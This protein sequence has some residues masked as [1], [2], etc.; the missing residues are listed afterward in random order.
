MGADMRRR[1]SFVCEGQTLAASLDEAPSSTGLLIISG[2]NEIRIG[3]HRGMAKLARDVA[4][5]GHPV[6]RF[7]RR[8]IGDSE[9]ENGG[10][11]ASG[12]DIAAA[13]AA[14][15]LSCPSLNRIVAF[16]NCDAATALLLHRPEGIAAH[17][18]ANIWV[19][20]RADE[21]PPPAAIR[22][23]YS[24]RLKDPKAWIGLFTGAVNLRKLAT[25]L[26]RIARPQ[27]PA[28]LASDAAAGLAQLSGPVTIL[29]AEQDATAIAFADAW[30]S[31]PFAAARARKDINIKTIASGSHSFA[32]DE[33]YAWLRATILETLASA[34]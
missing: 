3:A 6:F 17:I 2:G 22:A 10:F 27:P 32:S 20:E 12:P 16:G 11:T 24:E 31:A 5:A 13:I 9:G 25:G 4:A 21:L 18:L 34:A 7:D 14:F 33:D 28:S 8:G 1:L 23:R 19:I 15:R 30:K 29:L 26:L